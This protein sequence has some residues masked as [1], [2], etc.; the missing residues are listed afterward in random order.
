MRP[1]FRTRLESLHCWAQFQ[2]ESE[3]AAENQL[4]V[5]EDYIN[6]LALHLPEIYGETFNMERCVNRL[7][8]QKDYTAVAEMIVGLGHI[9]H[10]VSYCRYALETLSD[11][12]RWR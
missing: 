7:R 9:A 11:E 8:Q 1:K 12:W 6:N 3:F 5:L 10:H 4:R 2:P